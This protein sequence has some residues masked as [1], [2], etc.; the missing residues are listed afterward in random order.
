MGS[1]NVSVVIEPSDANSVIYQT[2]AKETVNSQHRVKIGLVID[3]TN[4][5]MIDILLT[6]VNIIFKNSPSDQGSG[7]SF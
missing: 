2:L 4:N 5:G 7:F 1:P 6:K 3:I